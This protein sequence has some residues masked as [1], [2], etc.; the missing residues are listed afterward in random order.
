VDGHV[1]KWRGELVD[2][3]YGSLVDA[4]HESRERLWAALGATVEDVRD[5]RGMLRP[6]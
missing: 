6:G 5:G 4:A 3:D 2:L 1:R